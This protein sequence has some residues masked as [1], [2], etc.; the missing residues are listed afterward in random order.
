MAKGMERTLDGIAVSDASED[1]RSAFIRRTY[2]HLAAAIGIFAGIEAILLGPLKAQIEPLVLSM[3][4][5]WTWLLVL[6]AFMAVGW[7]ADRWARSD[8]SPTMQYMGLGL[9]ILAEAFIFLPLLYIAT[10]FTSP[11]VLPT[12]AILTLTLFGGLTATVF[13]T[14]KDFSFLRTILAVGGFI[15]LGVIV[16][17]ITFGFSLGA[18]FSVALIGLAAG[19]ILYYTS[20]VMHHYRPDQHVAASLALFAAV[21]LMFYYVLWLL[22]SLSSNSA[23]RSSRPIL[24]LLPSPCVFPSRRLT[25]PSTN[26]T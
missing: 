24:S 26:L 15:A 3:V 21:A 20:Q 18:I 6:V 13:I 17:A 10:T 25:C 12:A 19:Y 14:R 16:V 22:I 5:G 11:D 7:I 23:S 9:Y 1:V 2:A 8:M 4:Q